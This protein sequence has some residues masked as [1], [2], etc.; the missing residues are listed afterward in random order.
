MIKLLLARNKLFRENSVAG[1]FQRI[2]LQDI[3]KWKRIGRNKE[4]A[5]TFYLGCFSHLYLIY[6]IFEPTEKQIQC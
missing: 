3:I 6:H 5:K 2:P 4:K 1:K